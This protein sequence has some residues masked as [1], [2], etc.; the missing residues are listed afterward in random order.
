MTIEVVLTGPNTGKTMWVGKHYFQNGVCRVVVMPEAAAAFLTFMARSCQ[1][2]ATGSPALAAKQQQDK[3]NGLLDHLQANPPPVNGA[4]AAV[5]GSEPGSAGTLHT[6]GA[7]LGSGNAGGASR[8]SGVVSGGAGHAD[9]GLGAGVD[10]GTDF[11]SALLTR[12]RNTIHKLDPAQDA[13]WTPEGLPSVEY[14]ALALND[15]KVSR[16]AIEVAAPNFTRLT[17]EDLAAL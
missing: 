9:A 1:A 12:I 17:A 6:E 11:E 2:Y 3:A 4:P 15:Q 14:I 10:A 16:K 13:Q 8:G 7:L 5:Q